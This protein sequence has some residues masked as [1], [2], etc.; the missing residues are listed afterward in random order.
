MKSVTCSALPYY[1]DGMGRGNGGGGGGGIAR[2]FMLQPQQPPI[3][4]VADAAN[5]KLILSESLA[6]AMK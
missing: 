4:I 3:V 6:P 2:T 1:F 5:A